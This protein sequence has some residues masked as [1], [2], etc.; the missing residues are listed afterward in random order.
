MAAQPT[1]VLDAST[2]NA[3]RDVAGAQPPP[4]LV[5]V[6]VVSLVRMAGLR[7]RGPR[8]ERIGGMPRTRGSSPWLSWVFAAEIPME[9]GR[10]VR[11]VIKWISSPSCRDQ[12][13]RARQLPPFRARMFTESMAQRDQ[14]R[15]PRA[16]SSSSTR[17]WSLPHTLALLHSVNRRWAVAPDGPKPTRSWRHVQ[18]VVPADGYAYPNRPDGQEIAAVDREECGAGAQWARALRNVTGAFPCGRG[19]TP[20]R[21]ISAS[22]ACSP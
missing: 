21:P 9:R 1:R 6:E 7:R 13:I 11:S 22:A 8:R 10:P 4:Q 3:R 5:E 16:P 18:P 2:G 19:C 20:P 17:R 15:S 12:Q 14:S